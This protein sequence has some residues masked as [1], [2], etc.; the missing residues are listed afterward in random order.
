M[1][2]IVLLYYVLMFTCWVAEEPL[3][4][5]SPSYLKDIDDKCYF[6]RHLTFYFMSTKTTLT[7]A[8]IACFI[9]NNQWVITSGLIFRVSFGSGHWDWPFRASK[10]DSAWVTCHSKIGKFLPAHYCWWMS[11]EFCYLFTC[12]FIFIFSINNILLQFN[13]TTFYQHSS[14]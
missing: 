3:I 8:E 11:G 2:F 7:H 6:I 13:I 9:F 1:L 5:N 14:W 10:W 12:F 4:G